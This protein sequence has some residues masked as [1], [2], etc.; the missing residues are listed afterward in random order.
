MTVE[1]RHSADYRIGKVHDEIQRAVSVSNVDGIGPF[2]QI[3]FGSR[4]FNTV[5]DCEAQHYT[6]RKRTTR[7]ASQRTLFIADHKMVA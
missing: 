6:H 1:E 2:G 5:C 3:Q 7:R 4:P